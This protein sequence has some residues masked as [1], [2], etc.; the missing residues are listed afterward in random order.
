MQNKKISDEDLLKIVFS[1]GKQI[2]DTPIITEKT[3]D[4]NVDVILLFLEHFDFKPGKQEVSEKQLYSLFKAWNKIYKIDLQT[5]RKRISTFFK[6]SS[7]Y[8]K[9]FYLLDKT[10]TSIF[11]QFSD[12]IK[13]PR[14][15]LLKN[16]EIDKIYKLMASWELMPTN[17]NDI[18]WLETD[19]L[20]HLY[21]VHCYRLEQEPMSLDKFNKCLSQIFSISYEYN[22]I[23]LAKVSN[24]IKK[25]LTEEI[26]KSWREARTKYGGIERN[27]SQKAKKDYENFNQS[28][29]AKIIYK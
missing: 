29:N 24:N 3:K 5:F 17:D 22:T 12:L 9:R 2:D 21:D 1:E 7:K 23:R 19:I 27:K 15:I 26:V 25:L 4:K 20:Y 6:Q 13:K 16:N 8:G 11:R 14:I 10:G 28:T 18:V